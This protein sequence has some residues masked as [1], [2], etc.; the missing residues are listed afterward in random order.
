MVYNQIPL[1]LWLFHQNRNKLNKIQIIITPANCNHGCVACEFKVLRI[2]HQQLTVVV[3]AYEL[4]KK[5]SRCTKQ[6]VLIFNF[7]NDTFDV[8]I[9][10]T[11]I[12]EG[13]FEV[14]VTKEEDCRSPCR[15]LNT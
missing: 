6:N 11:S 15:M 8:L 7:D 5:A 2:A 13:I 3:F 12:K 14:K 1:I 10:T 9:L 4:D